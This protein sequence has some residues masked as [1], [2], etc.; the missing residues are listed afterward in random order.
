MRLYKLAVSMCCALAFNL[1]AMSDEITENYIRKNGQTV[2]EALNA[3]DLNRAERRLK[4]NAYIDQFSDLD[5]VSNFVIGKYS[6]R[7]S[8]EELQNYR[9]A[10]RAYSLATYETQ[11]DDYR[12]GVIEILGSIDRNDRDS[13]VD[14]I[15][16]RKDGQELNVQWR[17]Q[18]RNDVY[19]IIDVALKLEGNLIWLAIEQRAQFLDLLDRTNGSAESLIRKLDELTTDLL[20]KISENSDQ[21]E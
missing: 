19:Q 11:F 18:L 6:R 7:F 2:L 21:G 14:S 16:R 4:F 10:F 3:P 12:G 9:T 5:R 13:I 15:I 20:A 17:I 1:S 8:P